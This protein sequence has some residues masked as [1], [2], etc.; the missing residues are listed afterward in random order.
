[1]RVCVIGLGYIGLPT[2][3]LLAQQN[4]V[5]GVDLK[6]DVVE[7]INNKV[8]PFEEPG[9]EDLLKRSGMVA[10][11]APRPADA[12]II[13]VPTPFDKEVRMADLR[14]SAAEA[15]ALVREIADLLINLARYRQ[16]AHPEPLPEAGLR[17]PAPGCGAGQAA[18]HS[19]F[20]ALPSP[21][22]LI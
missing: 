21:G 13:C 5:V 4:T 19:A 18:R 12:F 11:T 2:A 1:M 9:L 15:G 3:L 22:T 8:M 20:R 7:K 17:E 14:F 10:S 16:E 6:K